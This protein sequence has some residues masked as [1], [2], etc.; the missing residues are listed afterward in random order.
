MKECWFCVGY[1]IDNGSKTELWDMFVAAP[2]ASMA[3][4]MATEEVKKYHPKANVTIE[5]AKTMTEDEM[6]NMAN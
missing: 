4:K 6:Y 5:Y 1:K 2:T 3:K